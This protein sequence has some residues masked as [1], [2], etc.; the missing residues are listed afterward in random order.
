MF[1]GLGAYDLLQEAL[2]WVSIEELE[3]E[4]VDLCLS[5]LEKHV[6]LIACEKN[7]R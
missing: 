4:N 6:V 2:A 7:V 5:L 3:F 1:S